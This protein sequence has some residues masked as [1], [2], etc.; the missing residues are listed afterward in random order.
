ML[1]SRGREFLLIA[2][3]FGFSCYLRLFQALA[4]AKND[5][6][7][8]GIVLVLAALGFWMYASWRG[9]GTRSWLEG[10]AT[11]GVSTFVGYFLSSFALI[12]FTGFASSITPLKVIWIALI[13]F[14]GLTLLAGVTILMR[15]SKRSVAT[16]LN[17][18]DNDWSG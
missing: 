5:P 11:V 16:K 9:T 15:P 1:P 3:A 12:I 10:F 13:C 4:G 17:R 8:L 7:L 14:F 18:T 2:L 6:P